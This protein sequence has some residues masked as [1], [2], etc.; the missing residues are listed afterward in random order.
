MC[1]STKVAL[2]EATADHLPGRQLHRVEGAGQVDVDDVGP[3]LLAERQEGS[4]AL[5][6][7]VRDSDVQPAEF[8]DAGVDGRGD[9]G[10]ACDVADE[11]P[12]PARAMPRAELCRHGLAFCRRR[13]E[14][15][16]CTAGQQVLGDAEADAASSAGHQRGHARE[17]A[18][19]GGRVHG[20]PPNSAASAS[21][22]IPHERSTSASV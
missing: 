11:V 9:L 2:V 7:G 10:P 19:S 14:H 22:K 6:A 16:R 17:F 5:D 21:S 13:G 3:V 20:H 18:L 4:A 15:D 12:R 8:R 1:D